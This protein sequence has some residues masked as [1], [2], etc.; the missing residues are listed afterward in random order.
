M[1][2]LIKPIF[3]EVQTSDE[4]IVEL[5]REITR[6]RQKGYKFTPAFQDGRW[7][8]WIRL[9]KSLGGS[10]RGIRFPTGLVPHVLYLLHKENLPCEIEDLRQKP[11]PYVKPLRDGLAGIILRD[12]QQ[13]MVDSIA[14][15][16]IYTESYYKVSKEAAKFL[17]S[18]VGQETPFRLPGMGIW[19]SATGCHVKGQ[20]I[21]MYNREVKAVEDIQVGELLCGPDDMPRKVKALIRGFGKLFKLIPETGKPIIVNEDHVL[22]LLDM[23]TLKWLDISLSDWLRLSKTAK[24]RY[25][26]MRHSEYW[27]TLFKAE[28]YGEG[29]FFGFTLDKDGRYLLD[30]YTITHNS[31][32]TEAAA[33]LIGRLAVPSLFLVYGTSLVKQT[34]E[35]FQRRLSRWLFDTDTKVGITT[36]G[37]LDFQFITVASSTTLSSI[38]RRP[39]QLQSDIIDVIDKISGKH[40]KKNVKAKDII[41]LKMLTQAGVVDKS[42]GEILGDWLHDVRYAVSQHNETRIVRLVDDVRRFPF[43]EKISCKYPGWITWLDK[44]QAQLPTILSRKT[45]VEQYLQTVKLLILDEAH[46]GASDTIEEIVNICPAYYKC[47]MSGTPLDRSDG[48]NLKIIGLFGD[49][50]NRI[51][52]AQMRDEGV[53]PPA[54]IIVSKIGGSITTPKAVSFSEIESQGIVY[55]APRNYKI[56]RHIQE[57]Y[58]EERRLFVLVRVREHGELLSRMLWCE[59]DIHEEHTFIPHEVLH[60]TPLPHERVDGRDDQQVRESIITKFRTGVI[61]IV[62]A[63]GIFRTGLD[64]PEIDMI[65]RA[66][67]GKG[68]IP[69]KQGIG[70]SLRGDSPVIIRDYADG[71][72]RI[73]AKHSI[74]RIKTYQQEGC[75]HLKF[76]QD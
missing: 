34:Y 52:N 33:A 14:C 58:Q 4:Y 70:R 57:A 2:L 27:R 44:Y 49:V 47:G 72:H 40:P 71:H 13:Y 60:D 48:A 45:Q 35:R 24:T 65:I 67:G 21:L 39:K 55:Y 59:S 37:T 74:E 23:K 29:E 25:Y 18:G 51:T 17:F 42:E 3:S 26:W 22:T 53:I 16:D 36:E 46:G 28:F 12:Y 8:G 63:S 7:D 69:V 75:F 6:F 38:L 19:W 31:G 73:L 41:R 66:D 1:R 56:I 61:R 62:I 32:K 5:I 11:L 43:Y 30:D 10:V 9:S 54:T 76:E 20:Q 68:K 15:E 64:V 50:V